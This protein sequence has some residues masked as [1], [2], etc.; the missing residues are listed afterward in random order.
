MGDGMRRRPTVAL[1][2]TIGFLG[3]ACESSTSQG[4]QNRDADVAD[5]PA[6]DATPDVAAPDASPDVAA[7]DSPGDIGLDRKDLPVAYSPGDSRPDRNGDVAPSGSDD[8]G[9]SGS[10]DVAPDR[11]ADLA[12][13]GRG[14]I[15]ATE[16]GTDGTTPEARGEVGA[17]DAVSVPDGPRAGKVTCDERPIEGESCDPMPAGF[18]CRHQ[19][20]TG[21]CLPECRCSQGTWRCATSCRDYFSPDPIDCGTPPLCREQCLQVPVLADGGL[22]YTDGVTVGYRYAVGF[23]P[24]DMTTLWGAQALRVTVGSGPPLDRARLDD[25]A[26]RITLR[27]WPELEV[28]PST[29]AVEVGVSDSETARITVTPTAKLSE[30]WYALHLAGLPFWATAQSHVAADGAY[31]ARFAVGSDPRVAAVTFAGGPSKRRLYIA[32]SELLQTSVSPAT[33]VQVRQSGAAVVCTDVGFKA[34]APLT[35][36]AF[37]CPTLSQ[38]PDEIAIGSGFVSTTGTA[39]L[40]VVVKK[41]DLT[42]TSCGSE[43][44]VGRVP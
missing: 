3:G 42:F 4:V 18:F 11:N 9:P 8:V 41:A 39:L 33:L 31:L 2:L 20:C 23:T 17:A 25:L 28:V 26:S 40:P 15:A 38:F 24:I 14:D 7:A 16:A 10:G 27:T 22:A 1:V 37:D 30:R 35:E 36:I 6:R 13:E 5:L 19:S 32:P 34:N 43:C 29:S 21:G 44:E 12:P